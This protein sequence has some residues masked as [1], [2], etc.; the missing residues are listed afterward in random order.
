[1]SIETLEKSIVKEEVLNFFGY[2]RQQLG[3]YG[4]NDSEFNRVNAIEEMYRK[5]EL[6]EVDA[7]QQAQ[8]IFDNK[9]ER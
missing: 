9:V 2:V 4:N 3:T 7:M 5:G 8:A 6:G 1:M